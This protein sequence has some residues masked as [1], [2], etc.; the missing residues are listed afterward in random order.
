MLQ[1][2]SIDDNIRCVTQCN[3]MDRPYGEIKV[4]SF[5][6]VL[7]VFLIQINALDTA[8]FFSKV[9]QNPACRTTHFQNK[10]PERKPRENIL[11]D[12]I[13]IYCPTSLIFNRKK[14]FCWNLYT[15]V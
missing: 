6:P 15:V 4:V 14:T 7:D 1:D 2:V 12:K 3:V 10:W 13:V 5:S 8:A 9:V 11:S